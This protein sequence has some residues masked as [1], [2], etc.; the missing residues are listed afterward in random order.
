MFLDLKS[1]TS[2]AERLGHIKFSR[3]LQD[4]F[5]DLTDTVKKFNMEIH[6]YIGDEVVLT[7]KPETGLKNSN[8]LRAYFDYIETISSGRSAAW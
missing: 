2:H 8:C 1:S 7:W 3:L 4:C 5:N 6:K